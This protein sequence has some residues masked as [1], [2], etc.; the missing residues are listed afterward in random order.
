MT[1]SNPDPLPSSRSATSCTP[2]R[3]IAS[4]SPGATSSRPWEPALSSCSCSGNPKKRFSPRNPARGVEAASGTVP[5][6]R[7]S[8]PGCT[9]AKR[10]RHGLH[11]QGRGRPEHPHR[12]RPGRRRRVARPPRV[13]RD[14]HGR[15][16]PHAVRHGD[17]RQPERPGHGPRAS[18]GRRRRARVAGRTGRPR[19]GRSDAQRPPGGDGHRRMRRRAFGR[20]WGA[21]P[22]T[23]P[24]PRRQRRSAADPGDRLAGD[25]PLRRR[26]STVLERHR[27]AQY[28][29]DIRRPGMLH[30]KVLRPPA[31]GAELVSLDTKKAELDPRRCRRPRRRFR[32]GGGARRPD[33]RG[34][35][36]RDQAGWR[37][38]PQSSRPHPVRPT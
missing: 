11:R 26:R 24:D 29:S 6:R 7:R 8:A 28:A 1:S 31:F 21:D 22:G 27:Q 9:S 2:I 32:R 20:L 10:P 23:E 13:D 34:G 3:F 18:P 16:R 14:G 35:P 33:G 19:S 38:G 25:G 36:R 5:P 17:V 12:A 15:H 37:A 4:R 30:G